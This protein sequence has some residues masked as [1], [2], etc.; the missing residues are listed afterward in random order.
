VTEGLKIDSVL[1]GSYFNAWSGW[2]NML[3]IE[4]EP[5]LAGTGPVNLEILEVWY[6]ETK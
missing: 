5:S 6:G 3:P 2:L 4:F 1:S